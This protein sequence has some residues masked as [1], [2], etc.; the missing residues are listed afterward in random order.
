MIHGHIPQIVHPSNLLSFTVIDWILIGLIFAKI[1]TTSW[2]TN[3][4]QLPV[5][6]YRSHRKTNKSHQRRS[7]NYNNIFSKFSLP[8]CCVPDLNKLR[9]LGLS[10]AIFN[11]FLRQVTLIMSRPVKSSVKLRNHMVVSKSS[12]ISQLLTFYPALLP[13]S[14]CPVT[15]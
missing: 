7:P 10:P 11:I 3:S 12:K 14:Q 9:P 15:C 2:A 13:T 5:S 8:C 4:K 1:P 6:L